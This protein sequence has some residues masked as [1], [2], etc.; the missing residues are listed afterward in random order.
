MRNDRADSHS[1]NF[2][3]IDDLGCLVTSIFLLMDYFLYRFNEENLSTGSSV[4]FLQNVSSNYV[5]FRFSFIC[6]TNFKC[7]LKG[8]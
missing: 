3:W 1:Y 2:D 7:L 8:Y 4:D 6:G 5:N